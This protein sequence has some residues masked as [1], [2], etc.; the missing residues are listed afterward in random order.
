MCEACAR[1]CAK[2]S[3]DARMQA[4]AQTCRDCAASCKEMASMGM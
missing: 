2:I 1:D 3:G 4:C